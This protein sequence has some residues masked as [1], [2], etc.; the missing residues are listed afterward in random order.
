MRNILTHLTVFVLLV[1]TLSL[2]AEPLVEET[3]DTEKK[4]D[5]KEMRTTLDAVM[6]RIE[7]GDK[8]TAL[9][10]LSEAV[11][12]IRNSRPL[13]IGRLHLCT[14]VREFGD[15]D[16][17]EEFVLKAGEPLLL[18]MEPEGY[19]IQ[20][21]GDEYWISISQDAAIQDAKGETIFQRIEWIKYRKAF[22]SPL[23]PFYLTNR[24]REIP[25][26]TYTYSL[27]LKDHLKKTFI[28]KSFQFKV[29]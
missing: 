6:T 18:Y 24:V 3:A 1:F 20:K 8:I 9:R 12:A 23:I 11:M 14:E 7:A 29:E 4:I 15:F 25:V 2:P 13:K 10:L 26:G 28:I 5:L 21:K 19:G 17:R 22:Q 27:T 16:A